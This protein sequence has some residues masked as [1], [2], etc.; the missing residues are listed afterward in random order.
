MLRLFAGR[1]NI[2][3]E[4]FIYDRVKEHGGETLVLVPDQYTLVAEEQ[5]LNYL[6]T[7]CLFNVE[8]TS[9]NRLGLKVLTEQGLESVKMIDK[10]GR[11]ML[12]SMLIREHSDEFDIFSRVA[13]KLTFTSMLNDFISEFKQQDCTLEK[14]QEMTGDADGDPILEAK[15]KELSGVISAYEEAIEGRY[16]DSEDYIAMYVDAIKDSKLVRG[17]NIW[18]YGYD[19][20]TSKFADAVAELAKTAGSV[21]FIVNISDFGLDKRL[22]ASLD[23]TEGIVLIDSSYES[24]K[25][26]SGRESGEC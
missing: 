22:V 15:L 13:G 6:G 2:D 10:Y 1:E 25:S 9:M 5:A 4:R 20:I 23:V 17:K 3:K 21:N 19:S 16:T 14:L 24:A 8:I 7:D 12:L 26:E 18:I 11:F